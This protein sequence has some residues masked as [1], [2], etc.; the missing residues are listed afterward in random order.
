MQEAGYG[1]VRSSKVLRSRG[2]LSPSAGHPPGKARLPATRALKQGKAAPG[3]WE[4]ALAHLRR[5]T[6][7]TARLREELEAAREVSRLDTAR[8]TRKGT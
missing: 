4:A 1:A 8:A 7:D 3:P 5:L 6:T 2:S